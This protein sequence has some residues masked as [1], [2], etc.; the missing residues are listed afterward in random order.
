MEENTALVRH[1]R[2]PAGIA[3]AGDPAAHRGSRERGN[4]KTAHVGQP[5]LG[6]TEVVQTRGVCGKLK[7]NTD[8]A[9]IV[10][11]SWVKGRPNKSK[12]ATFGVGPLAWCRETNVKGYFEKPAAWV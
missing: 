11:R 9:D 4:A 1:G 6:L 10:S 2:G 7:R 3:G 5:S 12:G 8:K